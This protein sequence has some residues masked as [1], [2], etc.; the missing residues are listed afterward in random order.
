MLS[1]GESKPILKFSS[2]S[3]PRA[4]VMWSGKFPPFWDDFSWVFKS[5]Q[6]LGMNRFVARQI[7]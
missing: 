3:L 1:G 5:I 6:R 4:M 7:F 2:V